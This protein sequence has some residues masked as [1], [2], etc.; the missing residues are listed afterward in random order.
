MPYSK[1]TWNILKNTCI[2]PH[3]RKLKIREQYWVFLTLINIVRSFAEV[4][5]WS[6]MPS[7]YMNYAYITI[8]QARS[9]EAEF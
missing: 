4:S 7:A 9:S 3:N 8:Q 5:L 6:D 2:A 1:I